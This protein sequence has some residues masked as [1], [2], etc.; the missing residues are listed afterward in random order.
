M[1]VRNLSSL[2]LSKN[3]ELISKET[4]TTKVTD[5]KLSTPLDKPMVILL[6]WLMAKRKHI[7]KFANYYTGHGFDVLNVSVSPWQLLWPTKGTQVCN[8][9]SFVSYFI[10]FFLIL[11]GNSWQY[12]KVS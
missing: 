12:I 7:Y 1:N 8:L 4:K 6:S 10:M 11:I 2:E 5:L 9:T 3:L